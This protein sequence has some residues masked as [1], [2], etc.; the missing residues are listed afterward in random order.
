LPSGQSISLFDLDQV[1]KA[2]LAAELRTPPTQCGFA[3]LLAKNPPEDSCPAAQNDQIDIFTDDFENDPTSR[4]VISRD[5]A[6]SGTFIPRDWLWVHQLP[7]GRAGSGFFG[8]DPIDDCNSPDPGQVGVLHL[9]SPVINLP[10]VMLGGPHVSFDHYVSTEA[11]SDGGQL[12][13]SV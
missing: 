13:I 3:P 4:W 7:D 10:R 6:D 8:P 2:T 12:L 5:V 9:D 1:H 11:G